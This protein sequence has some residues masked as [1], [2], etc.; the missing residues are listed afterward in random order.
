[1]WNGRQDRV[2]DGIK[3]R[4]GWVVGAQ[5]DI[6]LNCRVRMENTLM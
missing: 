3:Q 6:R 5:D 2:E 1:M 4:G